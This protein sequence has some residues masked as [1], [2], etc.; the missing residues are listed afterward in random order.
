L[1]TALVGLLHQGQRPL[2]QAIFDGLLL[3][4]VLDQ[5][6]T[7]AHLAVLG[8]VLVGGIVLFRR[9]TI[10]PFLGVAAAVTILVGFTGIGGGTPR[11]DVEGFAASARP[12]GNS[13]KEPPLLLHIILD[14]HIGVEGLPGDNP[15]SAKMK[16]AL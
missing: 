16:T 6:G 5:N 12:A 11:Q 9:R 1:L 15:R 13:G 8:G 4:F 14:E 7:G 3:F 2:T 10:L